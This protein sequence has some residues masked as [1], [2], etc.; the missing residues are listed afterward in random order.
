MFK[1]AAHF[2]DGKY[3]TSKR[4]VKRSRHPGG[5]AC[6]VATKTTSSGFNG[7]FNV[8]APSCSIVTNGDFNISN[9]ASITASG[10]FSNSL[11][12]SGGAHVT[13]SNEAATNTLSVSGGA[14][15]SAAS[16]VYTQTAS[17]DWG[18]V[19]NGTLSLY[20]DST[21][22]TPPIYSGSYTPIAD[23]LA[24]NAAISTALGEVSSPPPTMSTY[25]AF[26]GTW[27]ASTLNPGVYS[28]ITSGSGAL[29]LNPGLYIVQG[30]VS[31]G[32]GATVTGNGVT[33]I[34]SGTINFGGGANIT[35]TP[36]TAAQAQ[37]SGGVAGLVLAG[38]STGTELLSNGAIPHIAGIA[39]YP[40]GTINLAG[41]VSM[42]NNCLEMVAG[43]YAL[44]NGA[45]YGFS[46]A[47]CAQYTPLVIPATAPTV[48]VALVQ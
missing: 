16:G 11:E 22:I 34:T 28:S 19:T 17:V 24:S 23:P 25:G 30:N 48:T 4:G 5:S 12:V 18:T 15:L 43:N 8:N 7:G 45:S 2:F 44:G 14:T 47:N 29:T 33:I 36:P 21:A 32:N 35:L 39:Y 42:L 9:G 37:S 6:L 26:T 41:G 40:N 1:R 38:T 31:I 46:S 27:Q 3:H 20:D 10:L 13:L